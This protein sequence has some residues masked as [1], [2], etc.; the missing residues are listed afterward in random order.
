MV[1]GTDFKMTLHLKFSILTI[2]EY[3]SKPFRIILN[4]QF[5][6]VPMNPS[7]DEFSRIQMKD[8]VQIHLN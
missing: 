8:I 7:S 2:S 3:V 1:S 4:L 6:S 5:Q